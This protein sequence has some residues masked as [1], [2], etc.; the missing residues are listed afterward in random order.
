MLGITF[1]E[2]TAEHKIIDET[3]KELS[4]LLVFTRCIEFFKDHIL[5]ILKK[6]FVGSILLEEIGW[7]IT[8]PAIWTDSAKKMMRLAAEEVNQ[9]K[10]QTKLNS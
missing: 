8:V 1:Q 2:I 7:V 10:I 3:G 4:A 9:K 5:T 6:R